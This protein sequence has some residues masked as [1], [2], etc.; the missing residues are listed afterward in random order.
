MVPSRG[1][2][3]LALG[4]FALPGSCRDDSIFKLKEKKSL[5]LSLSKETTP[6][7]ARLVVRISH[8][9]CL[10]GSL[11]VESSDT[12]VRTGPPWLM[13]VVRLGC[14]GRIFHTQT[15][16]RTDK[17][18]VPL[19]ED[20]FSLPISRQ[21][22][23][24]VVKYFDLWRI[25]KHAP[26]RRLGVSSSQP[27]PDRAAKYELQL[28]RLN[29][30]SASLLKPLKPK[31]KLRPLRPHDVYIRAVNRGSAMTA[32]GHRATNRTESGQSKFGASP[33]GLILIRHTW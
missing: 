13:V 29:L 6:S 14:P 25:F 32:I 31:A 2:S 9:L 7:G 18:G 19:L 23:N 3:F 26:G 10:P 30:T 21:L 11:L 5:N 12:R 27:Y 8:L 22:G 15:V 4:S 1:V 28:R 20:V 33:R 24:T 16:A 17:A